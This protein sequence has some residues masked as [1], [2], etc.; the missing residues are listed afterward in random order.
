[1]KNT[2]EE[3]LEVM[4]AID[5]GKLIEFCSHIGDNWIVDNPNRSKYVPAFDEFKYR[6][7][8]PKKELWCVYDG[9]VLIIAFCDQERAECYIGKQPHRS[10]YT[11]IHM[12]EA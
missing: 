1:M 12:V 6:V 9:S 4:K 5:E 11:I 10:N 3:A 8:P 2:F 7:K